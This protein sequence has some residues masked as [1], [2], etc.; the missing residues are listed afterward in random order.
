MPLFGYRLCLAG[1]WSLIVFADRAI[2]GN[3]AGLWPIAWV[4]QKAG[5]AIIVSSP[6]LFV[7]Q[8]NRLTEISEAG[9]LA[10]KRTCILITSFG[11]LLI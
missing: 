5:K 7:V 2:A 3:H 10:I 4:M 6:V 1:D 9:I 11:K 8:V